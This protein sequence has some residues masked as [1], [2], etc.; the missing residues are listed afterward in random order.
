[1]EPSSMM[2]GAAKSIEQGAKTASS[3]TEAATPELHAID[4]MLNILAALPYPSQRRALTWLADYIHHA[5][6]LGPVLPKWM[7]LTEA[8]PSATPTGV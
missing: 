5:P 8:A 7:N 3:L 6:P 2:T 4:S 1:M